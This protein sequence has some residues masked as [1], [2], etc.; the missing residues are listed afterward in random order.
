MHDRCGQPDLV[1]GD[2]PEHWRRFVGHKARVRVISLPGRNQVEIVSV[3]DDEHV[4]LRLEDGSE[5]TVAFDA[6]REAAL[7]VDW[8]I[9]GKRR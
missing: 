9:V 4:V 5:M 6:I 7:V 2:W 3:P 8:G 1:A